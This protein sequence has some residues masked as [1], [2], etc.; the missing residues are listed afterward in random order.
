MVGIRAK[1][2]LFAYSYKR[3]TRN[4]SCICYDNGNALN[5]LLSF[6]FP[7]KYINEKGHHILKGRRGT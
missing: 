5:S 1:G 6:N 7:L 3:Y 4:P 2:K